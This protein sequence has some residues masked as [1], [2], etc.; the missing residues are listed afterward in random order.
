MSA[1]FKNR[2]NE[3][4]VNLTSREKMDYPFLVAAQIN[5]IQQAILRKDLTIDN[6]S[7]AVL[8]LVHLIPSP[9][10]DTDEK[11]KV[12]YDKAFTKVQT[13]IREKFAGVT[14]SIE[15]HQAH[16]LPYAKEETKPNYFLMF[17]A[18]INLLYRR[19][20]IVRTEKTE[21][22]TG[23]RVRKKVKPTPHFK[24]PELMAQFA[25]A[26]PDTFIFGW[27][28]RNPEAWNFHFPD[29]PTEEVAPEVAQT[30]EDE[31][32]DEDHQTASLN[33]TEEDL[34][35]ELDE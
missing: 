8:G 7:E 24:D 12:D 35:E 32:F 27:K 11:F 16:G 30:Q 9:W 2:G 5:T 13:D 34:E 6:L 19:G 21:R 25:D 10:K 14:L 18:A 3:Q 17:Q 31:T 23:K 33:L 28:R 20:M 29:Q 15:W 22:T 26:E 4:T 1:R